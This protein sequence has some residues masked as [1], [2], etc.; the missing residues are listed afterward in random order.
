MNQQAFNQIMFGWHI[1]IFVY[2]AITVILNEHE[3]KKYY[4]QM[5]ECCFYSTKK[6]IFLI[7]ELFISLLSLNREKICIDM[8]FGTKTFL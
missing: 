7:I 8:N 1:I 4:K 2:E 5:C 3:L 6:K